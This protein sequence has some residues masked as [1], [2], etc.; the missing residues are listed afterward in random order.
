MMLAASIT[1]RQM[2]TPDHLQ[3]RVNTTG[4]LIAWGG[5]PVGALLGGLLAELMPV[6]LV[7]GLMTIAVAAG[8]GL[9]GWSCRRG[10]P[11]HTISLPG[12]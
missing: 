9:A 7:F 3:G 10:G 6:R 12:M 2:L 8:A 5:Q 4:R 1:L 11:L